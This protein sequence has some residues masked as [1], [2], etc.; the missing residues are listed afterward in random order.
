MFIEKIRKSMPALL[1]VAM[2][3]AQMSIPVAAGERSVDAGVSSETL[4]ET[5]STNIQKKGITVSLNSPLQAK[6]GSEV[7]PDYEVYVSGNKVFSSKGGTVTTVSDADFSYNDFKI[8]YANNKKAGIAAMIVSP[9]SNR[10]KGIE[11]QTPA[12]GLFTI[13]SKKIKVSKLEV[14]GVQDLDYSQSGNSYYLSQQKGLAVYY[15]IPETQQKVKLTEGVDYELTSVKGAA[16]ETKNKKLRVVLTGKGCFK[17]TKKVTF[18]VCGKKKAFSSEKNITVSVN[19]NGGELN[20]FD[21][22]DYTGSKIKP[23]VTLRTAKGEKLSEGSD[24]K[25]TY[26]KNKNPGIA[27][28]TITPKKSLKREFAGKIKFYFQ[29]AG[30]PM[31]YN[32]DNITDAY[33]DYTY[34][35]KTIT[36][37]LKVY[38]NG[39]KLTDKDYVV[40][41]RNAVDK[42]KKN[43]SNV[44]ERPTAYVF[45][46]G[47]YAGYKGMIY[48]SIVTSGENT[49]ED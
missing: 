45:G 35:G 27:V 2:I 9:S 38:E 15:T 48:Y 33:D 21:T 26:K 23:V 39:T 22:V 36:P 1:T 25:I 24:Y 31:T 34:T 7:K 47:K 32:N 11:I 17:G 37:K 49:E 44:S 46:K 43:A 18:T 16:R 29:I 14:T 13:S 41:L 28:I 3:S 6:T 4:F 40:V 12:T 42:K 19:Y 10:A 20:E 8:E 30:K 5:Q